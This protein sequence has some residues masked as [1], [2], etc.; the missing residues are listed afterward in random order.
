[1]TQCWSTEPEERPTFTTLHTTFEDLLS[2]RVTSEYFN[3]VPTV[4][5]SE[6]DPS[7]NI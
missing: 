6:P 2:K 4:A 7:P 3:F 5:D 1:M